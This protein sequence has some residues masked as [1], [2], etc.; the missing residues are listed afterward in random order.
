MESLIHHSLSRFCMPFYCLAP[1]GTQVLPLW[2]GRTWKTWKVEEDIEG[3]RRKYL[4]RQWMT[5]V[6]VA[7]GIP[8]GANQHQYLP[9]KKARLT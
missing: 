9:H 4:F 7:T 3:S 8:E 1:M 6:G 2:S 5:G